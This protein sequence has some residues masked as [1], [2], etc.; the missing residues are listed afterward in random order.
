MGFFI[1]DQSGL[2]K[3]PIPSAI[4]RSQAAAGAQLLMLPAVPVPGNKR[5]FC[6]L[7]SAPCL[8]SIKARQRDAK[9]QGC[10]S[11]HKE[12]LNQGVMRCFGWVFFFDSVAVCKLHVGK[13][14]PLSKEAAAATMPISTE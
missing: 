5:H 12:P 8:G 10:F 2:L 14:Q 1:H 6:S 7:N 4:S 13:M 3:A 9:F 11:N